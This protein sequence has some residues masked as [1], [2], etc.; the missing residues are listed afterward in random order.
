[1]DVC[2]SNVPNSGSACTASSTD[3]TFL[4]IKQPKEW[5]KPLLLIFQYTEFCKKTINLKN[6]MTSKELQENGGLY[7]IRRH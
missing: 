7:S 2:K 3:A 6:S 5:V 4:R 1:M